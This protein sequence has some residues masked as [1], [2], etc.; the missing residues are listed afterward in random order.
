M[1]RIIGAATVAIGLAACLL[2]VR[3]ATMGTP[4]IT[5]LPC[6][7]GPWQADDPAFVAL[8]GAK[9]YFGRTDGGA[10]RIEIPDRWNGD[11][12]LYAHGYRAAGG[13]DGRTLRVAD[14]PIRAHLIQQGFA[15]AASSYACNGYVPGQ[16]LDST[17]ALTSLFTEANGGRQ[18]RRTYLTGTSMGGHVTLLGMQEYPTMFAGGLAMCAAG[19]GLFDYYSAVGAAAEVITGVRFTR[20]GLREETS[21]MAELLGKPP[22]YTQEGRELASVE[23]R[24]SGGPR[25]FAMEGL[26]SRF[27]GNISGSALAGGA[28]PSN[29]AVDTTGFHLEI[30]PGLG[31]STEAL[32]SRAR[33]LTADPQ[34]RSASGPYEE[35]VPFDGQIERPVLTMH[36]TG[37]LF[38]PI[39]LERTLKSAVDAAGRDNL[40]AQRIYRIAGHCQFSQPEMIRS[41]DDLVA[42]S[43]G[44]AKPAGDDV[45]TDLR[46]AGRRFTNPLR[47]GDPGHLGVSP[48]R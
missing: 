45:T 33:R 19:P 3:V 7:A 27:L 18:P 2:P 43:T 20:D 48:T 25:P 4:G 6:G 1:R 15:W 13:K 37:D 35:L 21:R 5:P 16:G 41:F 23:V 42:W 32:N 44:G 36:G 28:S 22:D 26:A 10:Y 8:S 17:V 34:I 29:R 12:V 31:I 30:A 38:V 40:L 39:F 46:D 47:D 24:I 11:L 9:A 14:S